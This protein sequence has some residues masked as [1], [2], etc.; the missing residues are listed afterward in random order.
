MRT[1][2]VTYFTEEEEEFLNLLTDIGTQK[3]VAT[4]LV[5]F[6]H[7]PEATSR[8]IEHG[9][10]LRQPE[11]SIAMQYLIERGW[12]TCS[13]RQHENRGGRPHNVY[14]LAVPM[15]KVMDAIEKEKRDEAK[16][17]IALI[18]KLREYTR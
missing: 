18:G 7:T 5:F 10:G 9:T 16:S 15:T 12:V 8:E 13:Q 14:H 11:V 2:N 1:E 17:R 6:A 4:V 3:K